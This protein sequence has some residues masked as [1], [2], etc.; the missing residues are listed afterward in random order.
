MKAMGRDVEIRH[1]ETR[2]EVQ[3][4]YSA[5]DKAA[6]FFEPTPQ[7]SLEAGLEKMAEW[8]KQIGSRDPQPF[9]D[10]ELSQ[11]LPEGW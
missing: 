11:G 9:G 4:A 7:T 8:A 1:L 6:K 10:I 5:H 2:N 3:H